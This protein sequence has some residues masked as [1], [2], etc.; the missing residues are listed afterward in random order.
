MM[1]VVSGGGSRRT[2]PC[3]GDFRWND[4]DGS[5]TVLIQFQPEQGRFLVS[6]CC[7]DGSDSLSVQRR[8]ASDLFGE[9][10][11]NCYGNISI[12]VASART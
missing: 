10:I 7:L 6:C 2:G 11:P 3:A 8:G 4:L 5:G 9:S 1:F 12:L